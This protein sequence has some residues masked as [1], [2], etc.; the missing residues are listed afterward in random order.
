MKIIHEYIRK[1]VIMILCLMIIFDAGFLSYIQ[2]NSEKIFAQVY[3]ETLNKTEQKTI[4]IT[5]NTKYFTIN[6]L[7][8]YITELKLIARHIFLYKGMNNTNNKNNINY[9]S[10]I[11]VNNNN[12]KKIIEAD[13]NYLINTMDSF[14]IYKYTGQ[15]L[16]NGYPKDTSTTSLN[17][18][19]Y[20]KQIIENVK[21]NSLLLSKLLNEHNELNY[22]AHHYFGENESYDITEDKEKENLVKYILVILKS[23]YISRLIT[24]RQDLDII[25][26]L[27]L[28]DE[29]IFIY[30]PEDYRKINL[31]Q[32][33]SIN[34]LSKCQYNNTDLSDYP[35]CIY[36]H[37]TT[38]SFPNATNFLLIIKEAINYQKILSAFCIQLHMKKGS[39]KKSILCVEI[40]FSSFENSILLSESINF[41]FGI[42]NP[43]NISLPINL[44]DIL[45]VIGNRQYVYYELFNTFNNTETTPPQFLLNISDT[46]KLLNY[47]S[48]YHF[49]YFNMTRILNEHPDLKRNT[50]KFLEEYKYV[51]KKILSIE[52]QYKY[53]NK[54]EFYSFTFNRT[55]CR[56]KPLGNEYECIIDE[57]EMRIMP[58][59][60]NMNKVNEELIETSEIGS[61]HYDLFIYSIT[62]T[63]PK[64]NHDNII[65]IMT[66]KLIR[67]TFFYVML[68]FISFCFFILFINMISEYSFDFIDELFNNINNI[69]IDDEKREITYLKENKNFLHNGEMIKLN[70]IYEFIR[71][72]LII[73]HSFDKE[74]FLHQH[75]FDFYK[76]IQDIKK[77]NIKE[78]CNSFIAHFH[79]NNNIFNLS[80]N[81][82]HSTLN[83]IEE[84]ENAIKGES[85]DNDNKLKDTIKRSSIVTYLNEY[86]TFGVPP[87]HNR[88]QLVRNGV[89]PYF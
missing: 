13:L 51:V 33:R 41:E 53:I 38:D 65:S 75:H 73:K 28:N 45:I 71:K 15:L 59:V 52:Y 35:Y 17:Y 2:S 30:P 44:T 48:L 34:P 39:N 32:F 57:N 76:L 22:I 67:I 88:I 37:L 77:N 68:T 54:K 79:F 7:M 89:S 74:L 6:L 50:S 16:E 87:I 3:D 83:F 60:I 85:S 82:I 31:I 81:E 62:T 64:I 70:E 36:D 46:T 42:F 47:F 24:K 19:N 86:S 40:D 80:E 12:Q 29:E 20:Y 8:K 63:N 26:Y 78:I 21:D 49:I 18:I 14:K 10:K 4:E 43:L 11:F 84:N 55:I 58:L 56:K 23:M 72:A 9:N 5:R 27:I 69:E 66:I 25:R 61:D 1:L